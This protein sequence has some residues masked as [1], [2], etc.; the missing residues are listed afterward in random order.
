MK[1]IMLT[2]A[3]LAAGLP[4]AAMAEQPIIQAVQVGQENVRYDKGVPTLDLEQANG[5]M[6]IRP[7]P[8]DHGSFVFGVEVLN[9]GA[10]PANFDVSN[11]S[12]QVG[13]KP[14]GILTADRLIQQAKHRSAWSQI[15][16]TLLGGLGAAAASS[17]RDT[18]YGHISTPYGSYSSYYS[19]PS[20]AGQLQA[21]RIADQT[22]MTVAGMRAQLDARREDIGNHVIQ[23]T[24]VRPGQI[25]GGVIVL[26][27]IS[28]GDLPQKLTITVNWN[29]EQYPFAFQI[30]KSGTP[31]PVF[32]PT[33]ASASPGV[34]LTNV[35]ASA[36]GRPVAT[37]ATLSAPP[38]PVAPS[39]DMER[40][41]R[42]TAE[43]MPRSFAL[44]SGTKLTSYKASGTELIVTA[45]ANPS[46]RAGSD[47]W[48]AAAT[49]EICAAKP[50]AA[51]LYQG[52][53]VRASY[54]QPRART[55]GTIE[56][57]AESCRKV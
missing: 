30:A 16:M 51:I 11:F 46:M 49:A 8:M 24:T 27:K 29:G 52:G 34:G 42:R 2:M 3:T 56:V 21:D 26:E 38:R 44:D 33:T 47:E 13:S 55:L 5:A 10:V 1:T 32:T 36:R 50:F 41:V 57:N 19:A 15:G 39:V 23:L 54:V 45:I 4:A 17:E 40:I 43:V 14:V 20:L 25:Y 6:K 31:A 35:W 18:Y 28:T 53:S 48:R 37:P 22:A 12:I 7:L 9:A